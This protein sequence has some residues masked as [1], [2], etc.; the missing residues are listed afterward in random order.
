MS[1]RGHHRTSHKYCSMGPPV[2]AIEVCNR[3]RQIFGKAF[4]DSGL[5]IGRVHVAQRLFGLLIGFVSA[6]QEEHCMGALHTMRLWFPELIQVD[7]LRALFWA[8]DLQMPA[9]RTRS[10]Q[11]LEFAGQLRNRSERVLCAEGYF[12][13]GGEPPR[14]LSSGTLPVGLHFLGPAKWFLARDC[15]RD[16]LRSHGKQGFTA[17]IHDLDASLRAGG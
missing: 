3:W 8:T 9:S 2:P 11:F 1:T 12:G 14:L 6:E 10:D 16:L 15:C 13:A 4:L 7:E 5:W 17:K